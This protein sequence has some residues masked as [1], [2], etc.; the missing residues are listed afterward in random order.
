M[1]ER[2]P[3]APPASDEQN[4]FQQ[5]QAHERSAA[6]S[7]RG[8][9]GELPAALDPSRQQKAGDVG[10]G[11]QQDQADGPEHGTGGDAG[12]APHHA[13]RQR[14]NLS[15]PAPAG[16]GIFPGDARGDGPD[17]GAGLRQGNAGLEPGDGAEAAPVAYPLVLRESQRDPDITL[18]EQKLKPFRHHSHNGVVAVV[19]S[20]VAAERAAVAAEPALP[21]FVREHGRAGFGLRR[22]G[23]RERPPQRRRYAQRGEEL[24]ADLHR[25]DMLWF[26]LAGDGHGPGSG[27]RLWRRWRRPWPSR[28]HPQ[29]SPQPV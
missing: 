4:A 12:A 21:E 11:D 7:Q 29:G 25:R 22:L 18:L 5:L 9:Y 23:G 20:Y 26:A 19:Q 10:A 24:R 8:A 3:S 1:A 6:G 27:T 14:A 17:L 13:V 28:G 2:T 16:L 15:A